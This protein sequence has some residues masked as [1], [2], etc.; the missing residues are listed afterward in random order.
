M[1][2]GKKADKKTERNGFRPNLLDWKIPREI[3]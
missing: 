1:A 2:L 3:G